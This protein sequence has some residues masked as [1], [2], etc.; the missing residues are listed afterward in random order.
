[1]LDA[2]FITGMTCLNGL[3]TDWEI[4]AKVDIRPVIFRT[5]SRFHFAFPWLVS[6]LT[7]RLYH[8]R[9]ACKHL[10]ICFELVNLLVQLVDLNAKCIIVK[11]ELATNS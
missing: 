9:D 7:V 5:D 11:N 4:S 3:L 10:F 8:L 2:K 6:R 1:M